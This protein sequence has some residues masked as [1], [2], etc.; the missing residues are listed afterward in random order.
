MFALKK[1][2]SHV[3]MLMAT[4][5]RQLNGRINHF[6]TET[7]MVVLNS[8]FAL[9]KTEQNRILLHRKGS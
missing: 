9:A 7:S 8:S 3:N 6:N 4:E 1:V 2:V 5:A